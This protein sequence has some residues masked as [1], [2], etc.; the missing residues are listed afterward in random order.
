MSEAGRVELLPSL[1]WCGNA[2]TLSG[3]RAVR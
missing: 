2:G 3:L 1:Q